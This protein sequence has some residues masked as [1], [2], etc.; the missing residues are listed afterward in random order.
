M[1][2]LNAEIFILLKLRKRTGERPSPLPDK[3]RLADDAPDF[4]DARD[5]RQLSLDFRSPPEEHAALPRLD[6]RE[7]DR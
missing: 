6:S 3:R 5:F 1:L 7:D 4:H 2:P